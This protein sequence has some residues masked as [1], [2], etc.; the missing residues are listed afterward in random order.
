VWVYFERK[1]NLFDGRPK[2]VLHVAPELCLEQ[3]LRARLGDGGY[4]TADLRNPR[5]MLRMDVTA[6][7]QPDASFDVVFCS[8]VLE[9]VVD[10]RKAMR[11]FHRILKPGGWAVLLV[12]IVAEKTFEDLS[13]VDPEERFR[14]FGHVEHVRNYGPDFADRVREAGFSV[15][16]TYPAD[17]LTSAQ[18]ALMGITSAA[19]EV[20]FCER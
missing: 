19:G 10:D 18:R 4:V 2:R 20:F 1:T 16:I 17:L 3:R 9:H 6:I 13:I 14:V 7:E 15:S 5:A 8:H 12:P 11:E